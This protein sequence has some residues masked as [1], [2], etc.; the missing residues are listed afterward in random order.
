M[1]SPI[2]SLTA[3]VSAVFEDEIADADARAVADAVSRE[4]ASPG[5]VA[6]AAAEL[7][8]TGWKDHDGVF[9]EDIA[10]VVLR[11]VGGA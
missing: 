3:A 4:L 5:M 9:A 8:R 2:D 1:T 11:S 6:H 7:R 10:S